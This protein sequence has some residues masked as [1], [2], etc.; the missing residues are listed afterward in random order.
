MPTKSQ[1]QEPSLEEVILIQSG[2]GHTWLST[3]EPLT[4]RRTKLIRQLVGNAQWTTHSKGRKVT[5]KQVR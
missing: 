3:Y 1:G 4:P 5:W 2:R